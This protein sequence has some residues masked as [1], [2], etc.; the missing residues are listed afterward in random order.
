MTDVDEAMRAVA[1][2]AAAVREHAYAPYTHFPMGAAILTSGGD[3]ISG[4]LVENVSLGLAMC[5]E[6]VAL[7]SAVTH[8]QQPVMLA[9]CSERT[10]NDLTFPCGACLQVALEIGG[11]ELVVVAVDLDGELEHSTV[12][13]LLTRAPKRHSPSTTSS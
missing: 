2:S 10:G 1:T 3:T 11:P 7:F 9:V 6:R 4:A 13:E 12:V 5:A 8:R